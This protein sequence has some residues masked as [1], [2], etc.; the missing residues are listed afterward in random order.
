MVSHWSLSEN[1]PPQVFRT[2]L[3]ILVDLNNAVVWMVSTRPLTSKSSSPCTNPLMTVPSA[4]ITNGI[5]VI[6]MFHSLFSFLVR[7]TNLF[8]FLLYITFTLWSAVTAKS[9]IRQILSFFFVYY[10]QVWSSG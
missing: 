2:L 4:P 9:T 10:H 8:F 6:S 7:S 1:N 5:T 3:S